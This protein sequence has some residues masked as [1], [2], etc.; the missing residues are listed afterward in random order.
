MP[1]VKHACT[2]THTHVDINTNIHKHIGTNL[3]PHPCKHSQRHTNACIYC[4]LHMNKQKTHKHM[5]RVMS[6]IRLG[7]TIYL[8]F[9]KSQE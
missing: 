4:Q 8:M 1:T 5:F 6:G 2:H 7:T 3:Y 9:S